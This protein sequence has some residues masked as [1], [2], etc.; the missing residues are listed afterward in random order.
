MWIIWFMT[1][2][3]MGTGRSYLPLCPQ[4]WRKGSNP[5]KCWRMECRIIRC[6]CMLMAYAETVSGSHRLLVMLYTQAGSSLGPLFQ[7]LKDQGN[8]RGWDSMVGHYLSCQRST[9]INHFI[10]LP[11]SMIKPLLSR[12]S[13]CHLNLLLAWGSCGSNEHCIFLSN[14]FRCYTVFFFFLP[15]D[16]SAGKEEEQ[17]ER[18]GPFLLISGSPCVVAIQSLFASVWWVSPC[19]WIHYASFLEE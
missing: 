13:Q 5:G 9:P 19:Y 11:L 1:L 7:C 10:L 15:F 2:N 12:A 4:H 6:I 17:W 3:S 18:N 14:H 16:H 8:G